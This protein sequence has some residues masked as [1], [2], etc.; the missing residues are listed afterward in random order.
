MEQLTIASPQY[1]IR[2]GMQSRWDDGTEDLATISHSSNAYIMPLSSNN[3]AWDAV[4]LCGCDAPLILQYTVSRAHG[5]KARPLVKLLGRLGPERSKSARLVFVVPPGVYDTFSW[6]PWQ[7]AK[8]E[9][10]ASL[11]STLE[12]VQ[13]WVME[14]KVQPSPRGSS[15]SGG[16][17]SGATNSRSG[18][19]GGAAPVQA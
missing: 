17:G 6:Q 8:G 1:T 12:P 4:V 15:S 14:L 18:S 10:L 16:T 9:V 11:S 13:Q 7:T 3:A 5:I 19:A 2:S